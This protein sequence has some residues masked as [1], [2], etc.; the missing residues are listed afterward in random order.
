LAPSSIGEV[1]E[2]QRQFL[3]TYRLNDSVAIDA[4]ALGYWGN[5]HDQ[6]SIQHVF[7][8]HSHIDHVGSLPIF[9]DNIYKG[10][11]SC[12]T[13][14]GNEAVLLSLRADLFNDRVWPDFV[15]MSQNSNKPFLKLQLLEP[16]RP[17]VVDGLRITGVPVHHVVPTLGFIVDDG[18]SAI[19]ISS[20][21]GPTDALWQQANSLTNLK[22]VF[23]EVTFPERMAALA[24]VS[25]HLTPILFA[26]EVRK[27][28]KPAPVIA[29]HFKARVRD[30]VVKE[31]Q[32]QHIPNLQIGKFGIPYT[33]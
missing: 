4:G 29:V 2:D 9:V 33:F 10:T 19:V 15:T 14:Y 8:S 11:D 32:A 6:A 20:D 27:L 31:L 30:E 28:H 25:A 13:I 1:G 18:S 21:T 17:I 26:Q 23:L 22:A 7:L 24:R 3:T 16:G 12:V 5:P